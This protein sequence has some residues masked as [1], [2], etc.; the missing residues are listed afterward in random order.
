ML[1]QKAI[2]ENCLYADD[3]WIKLMEIISDIP[4]VLVNGNSD[5][6]FISKVQDNGLFQYNIAHND[7]QKPD[8][9]P[10]LLSYC[11]EQLFPH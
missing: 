11:Q 2:E 7:E 5:L 4:V 8:T 1:D 6:K 3:I 10:N 9:I